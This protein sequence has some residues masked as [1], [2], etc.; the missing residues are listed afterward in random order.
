MAGAP[1]GLLGTCC[2]GAADPCTWPWDHLDIYITVDAGSTFSGPFSAPWDA[3]LGAYIFAN[4][5]N[6]EAGFQFVR[7]VCGQ[8]ERLSTGEQVY[9]YFYVKPCTLCTGRFRLS[10]Y[11]CDTSVTWL[12]PSPSAHGFTAN[13]GCSLTLS[14]GY[15]M[16][17][18]EKTV[19]PTASP[20]Y[21]YNMAGAY[22]SAPGY[23]ITA[24]P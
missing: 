11:T 5:Y 19:D 15:V 10:R 1:Y 17:Q 18:S 14:T 24:P 2:C 22:A 13:S 21:E 3:T 4:G 23:R 20:M 7:D 12:L 6:S 16:F 8:P 9:A